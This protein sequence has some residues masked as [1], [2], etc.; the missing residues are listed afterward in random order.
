M[1]VSKGLLFTALF[2]VL[3]AFQAEAQQ[4]KKTQK[5][6]V[7]KT[8]TTQ[9]PAQK[10]S[11]VKTPPVS[12]AT[13]DVAE[14][15]KKVR[16]MVAFLE[17]ML[18]TLGNS[19]TSVRDK[20][21]LV[22]Q[23]YSKIFRDAKVQVE[24]D[25]DADRTVITNKDIV[26]YLKDVDFFYQDVT[27]EFAVENI[28]SSTMAD[29]NNF[30]KVSL[31]RNL[32]GTTTEGQLIN[33]S[34]PRFVEINY[35]PKSQDLKIVSI[36][37]K[38]LD[39]KLALIN[40]WKDLSYE[41]QA[42]FK[43]QLN[44]VDS[45][46]LDKIKRV[47]AIET[48]DLSNNRY[49]QTLEPLA[50]L[51]RLKSL[52][53]SNTSTAELN[54]VRNMTEL[55][56]IN[57]S[58][59]RIQD[60]SPLKYASLLEK[61]DASHTQIMDISVLEKMPKLTTLNISYTNVNDLT[62][63]ST[64]TS[65]QVLQARSSKI[66]NLAPLSP[67][68]ALKEVNVAQTTL[69]DVSALGGL[70]NVTHLTLDS[71]YVSNIQ[72]LGGM[73]NLKVL[74]LNH[75]GVSDLQPLQ[76]LT[77]LEKIYCDQT[78]ITRKVADAFMTTRPN[79]LIVFDTKDLQ[80]WWSSLPEDWRDAFLKTAKIGETSSNEALAKVTVIDSI[81]ISGKTSIHS[82]EP[83]RK[84]RKLRV[85][86]ADGTGITDLSPLGELTSLHYV[87]ISET[88]VS[89]LSPISKLTQLHTLRA[90]KSKFDNIEPL[91][92]LSKLKKLYVDQTMVQ[93]I[94]A[95]EFLEKNTDC[96]LIY[97]TVH[98]NRWWRGLSP[99]WKEVY[100]KQLGKD[101]T[102]TRENLHILTEREALVIKD[103]P[104]GDLTALSEFVRLKDLRMSATAVKDIAPLAN[105]N[106]LKTLHITNGPLQ[107][108]E[109]IAKLVTL[110]DVDLSNTPVNE[111]DAFK[112]LTAIRKLNFAGTQI[113][114]LDALEKM[115]SLQSLDCSNTQVSKLEPLEK[116]PL[117]SLKCYNTKIPNKRIESFKASKPECNVVYYR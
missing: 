9:K 20:E 108:V 54:A 59:T 5:Q 114:K 82:L 34:Q 101:T 77:H 107:N 51:S 17:Y 55:V 81:R 52:N 106:G 99:E 3:L 117:T 13:G 8:T 66:S 47:R 26:A 58:N 49:L 78:A 97:K 84:L 91:M 102:T 40:W 64:L 19:S 71:T 44:L 104:V 105:H 109:P 39:E 75:T 50:E 45:I 80:T 72:P 10:Q 67:L 110:E 38:Q 14:D 103:E 7:K 28:Q 85:L 35:D 25:L 43:R 63:L 62:A 27:F 29:G 86:V 61:L 2:V 21:V 96:L 6:P 60:L 113:K 15:E 69:Q 36:Y 74:Y 111:L 22:T 92:G 56:E 31:R 87:D 68:A 42:V 1:K 93:D 79:V 23:S 89:D 100:R 16:S 90:D 30:Y 76:K 37:T 41:W 98:L 24:D 11:T 73:D 115:T 53:I 33:N 48:L 83:L 57:I 18:N 65:L 4:K 95:R 88:P 70:K 46:T 116:L 12:K 112:P 94:I 32:K